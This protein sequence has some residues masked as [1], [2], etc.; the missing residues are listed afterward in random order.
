MST[1]RTE[2]RR[3]TQSVSEMRQERRS[4][5]RRVKDLQH[6]LD[7]LRA[8]VS[9]GVDRGVPNLPVEVAGPNQPAVAGSTGVPG[10]RIVAVSDDGTEIVYEG[11]AAAGK[12]ATVDDDPPS[13]PPVRRIASTSPPASTAPPLDP[14]AP[15]PKT[16]D[17]LDT[18]AK[19]APLPAS[20]AARTSPVATRGASEPT[21]RSPDAANAYQ[22]AVELVK[23]GK[24]DEGVSALRAFI[25]Q[26]P[27]HDYADNAQYWIGEAFYARK[28]YQTSLTEFRNVIETSPRGN[29]VP[30]ALLKVG[31][32]YQSLGQK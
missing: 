26:H 20:R 30:D 13:P 17:K 5:D 12:V 16:S 21:E 1:L 6:Q 22:A 3:L 2:N 8:Q 29:K 15:V 27:R 24:Y 23:G 32:C 4:Q 28:E 11:D 14:H 31:Y 18:Q 19:I 9:S 25:R 10:Q 7:Q